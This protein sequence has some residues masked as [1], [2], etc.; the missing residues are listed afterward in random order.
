MAA[1][2]V[3]EHL[4]QQPQWKVVVRWALWDPSQATTRQHVVRG[5]EAGEE[6]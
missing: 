3:K 4:Q 5:Q 1:V 6:G 2:V